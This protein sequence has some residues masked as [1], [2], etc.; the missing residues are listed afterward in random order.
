MGQPDVLLIFGEVASGGIETG[1]HDLVVESVS[2]FLRQ[3]SHDQPRLAGAPRTTLQA[4]TLTDGGPPVSRT[5]Y[6]VVIL[7]LALK[8][9]RAGPLPPRL[10]PG[11][12]AMHA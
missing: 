1:G 9:P 5:I 12:K 10:G 8:S 4:A 3:R 2:L 7:I 6:R 11:T